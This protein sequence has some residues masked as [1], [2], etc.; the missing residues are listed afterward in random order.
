MT[1]QEFLAQPVGTKDCTVG[2][3]QIQAL[4]KFYQKDP[5]KRGIQ[6]LTVADATASHEFGLV[7]PVDLSN[8]P[9]MQPGYSILLTG[10]SITQNGDYV[11]Y[12]AGG[13]R[14]NQDAAPTQSQPQQ[15]PAQQSQSRQASGNYNG[16]NS[17]I[18]N[19]TTK[20]ALHFIAEAQAEHLSRFIRAMENRSLNDCLD[21]LMQNPETL[22][23]LANSAVIALDKNHCLFRP[24][25]SQPQPAPEP[26]P[27]EPPPPDDENLPF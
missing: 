3:V 10:V 4:G 14:E 9:R 24:S 8:N 20:Q 15:A 2:P 18:Q 22:S 12:T 26:E 19:I 16:G 27:H 11:N 17:I 13:Y 6:R 5:N 21:A 1:V 7:S 23:A 25:H